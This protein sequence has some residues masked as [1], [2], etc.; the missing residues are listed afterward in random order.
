LLG[1]LLGQRVR[2][3]R[4]TVDALVPVPLHRRREAGRGYNQAAEIARYAGRVI[5]VPVVDDVA[6]RLR[7]TAEQAGLDADGRRRNLAGAFGLRRPPRFGRVAVVDDV[8]TTGST[9]AELAR[10][11]KEAGVAHVEAWAVARA[12]PHAGRPAQ[13]NR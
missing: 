13:R 11:F 2:R 1:T 7:P 4:P 9:A 10:A 3:R 12:L 6:E 5:G 8:M